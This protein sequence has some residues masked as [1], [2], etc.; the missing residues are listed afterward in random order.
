MDETIIQLEAELDHALAEQLGRTTSRYRDYSPPVSSAWAACCS[1][2]WAT[3]SAG[4]SPR[5]VAQ[6]VMPPLALCQAIYRRSRLFP[7]LCASW[8]EE[9]WA[10]TP[11]AFGIASSP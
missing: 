2:A 6:A 9:L 10:W 7:K 4:R 3:I 8:L 5:A 11:M 1:R